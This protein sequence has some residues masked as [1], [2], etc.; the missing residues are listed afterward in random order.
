MFDRILIPV[1]G[2]RCAKRAASHGFDLAARHDARV[3]V[4][5]AAG[6]SAAGGDIVGE[7]AALAPDDVA[8][9]RHVVEGAAHDCI[10]AHIAGH[11]VDLVAMGRQGRGSLA[12]WL[13]GS[14]AERVLRAAAVP[15]LTVPDGRVDAADYGDVLVTTDGSE[16]AE[17]AAPVARAVRDGARLHVLTAVDVATAA[18]VFDAGGVSD[19]YIDRLEGQG[20]EAVG[21]MADLVGGDVDRAVVRGS[22]APAIATY[23]AERGVDLV[24]IASA[25]ETSAAGRHLGTVAG[26]V[27]GVVEAPVLV[28]PAGG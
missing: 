14:V 25:G 23:V 19:A 3:D 16:H 20:R 1:D 5:H 7:A 6:G 26:R 15:V 8:V 27:L 11:G 4:L 12:E 28:V 18:G 10:A 24:V 17:A 9:E 21:R 13:L 2:S 22:P